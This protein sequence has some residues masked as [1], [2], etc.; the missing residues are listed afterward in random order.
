MKKRLIVATKNKKKLQEIKELLSSLD[1]Q[2][3]SLLDFPKIPRIIENA[4]TF[5]GNA[6]KKAVVTA[7]YFGSLALGEDSGLCID[8]LGGAPGVR[9][10]RFCGKN[11]SDPQNNA[12]VLKLMQGLP[13]GKRKAHYVCAVA[14]ADK[15]GLV[16]ACEGKC[17]GIIAKGLKGV[18]GFGYDPLFIVPKYNKTFAQ[19]GIRV[20][21]KISHRYRALSKTKALL[22][23]YLRKNP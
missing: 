22:S 17:F 13:K 3:V 20:K 18:F 15:K 14:L 2:V 4:K 12:R 19:L 6:V 5:K 9:S 1:L 7:R 21:H 10:S 23:T 16:G 11:K 8:A